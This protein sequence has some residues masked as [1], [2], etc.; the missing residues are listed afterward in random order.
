MLGMRTLRIGLIAVGAAWMCVGALGADDAPAPDFKRPGVTAHRAPREVRIEARATGLAAF[1]PCEFILIGPESGHGYEA[2]AVSLAKPS[3]VHAALEF[4]GLTPG[5]P[6]D[7]RALQFWPRGPRVAARIERRAADGTLAVFPVEQAVIDR[8]TRKPIPERGFMFIGSQRLNDPELG[9]D[10]IYAADLLQPGA[11]LSLFNQV[12]AVLDIPDLGS[13]AELYDVQAVHP[14]RVM[15]ADEPITLILTPPDPAQGWKEPMVVAVQAGVE[16][17]AA[18][19]ALAA[20]PDG[21]TLR[22]DSARIRTELAA[23]SKEH[24]VYLRVA[25]DR[26]LTAAQARRPAMDL[27]RWVQED[28]VRLDAPGP[29]QLLPRAFLPQP[30]FRERGERPSHP[31][32]LRFQKEDER[33]RVLVTQVTPDWQGPQRERIFL[34]EDWTAETPGELDQLVKTHGARLPVALVFAPPDTPYGVLADWLTPLRNSHPVVHIFA[35]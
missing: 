35:D 9:P 24:L 10:E 13:Q 14:D 12:G 1:E 28:L 17:D 26:T 11:I 33:W 32:E 21:N 29:D 30:A 34:T 19:F 7:S 18:A 2:V 27:D 22:G 3:D 16:Q 20:P 31:L 8:R 25:F 4:I 15:A 5:R 23:C 6:A